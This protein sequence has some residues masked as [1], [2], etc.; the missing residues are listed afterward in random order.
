MILHSSLINEADT[1]EAYR[2]KLVT[3]EWYIARL[4]GRGRRLVTA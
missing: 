2:K 1:R 4:F 3:G